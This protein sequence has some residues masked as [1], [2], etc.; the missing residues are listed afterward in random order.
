M[1]AGK[2]GAYPSEARLM[3]SNL[4][5]APGLTRKHSTMLDTAGDKHTSSLGTLVNYGHKKFCPRQI[6]P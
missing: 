6:I 5:Q 4:G 3:C 1:F 2:V